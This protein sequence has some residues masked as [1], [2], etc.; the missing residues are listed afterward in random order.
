MKSIPLKVLLFL[1]EWPH[2]GKLIGLLK[3]RGWE[4]LV[5]TKAKAL[6]T[7]LEK[8]ERLA[9]LILLDQAFPDPGDLD[10]FLGEINRLPMNWRREIALFLMGDSYR[11]TDSMMAFIQSLD[12]LISSKD[13]EQIP[14]LF[15]EAKKEFESRYRYWFSASGRPSSGRGFSP[16]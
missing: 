16:L 8:E 10:N 6:F 3:D 12:G 9:F 1:G 5:I 15:A 7:E 11:T 2:S 14:Q 13:W 4:P